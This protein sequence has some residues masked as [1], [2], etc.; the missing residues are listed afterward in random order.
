VR[1]YLDPNSIDSYRLFLRIKGLPRY[2]IVGRVAHF[3]SEYARLLGLE[4][5]NVNGL[6]PYEPIAGLF[7]YQAD[8][9]RLSIHKQKFGVFVDPGYG[10]TL[11][12]AEFARYAASVLPPE[13]CFLMMAPLNVVRQTV[14]E[15]IP[16]FYGDSLKVERIPS[17]ALQDWLLNGKSRIGITN[18]EALKK[19]MKAGRLGGLA[20][21]EMSFAKDA[22]GAYA[23]RLTD[24]GRGLRWKM[25]L[26]GTPAPNDR[27]EYAGYAVFLDAFPNVNAFYARFFVNRGETN[28]RWEMKAHAVNAF[29]RSLSDWCIFMTNPAT[30]GWKDN[31]GTIPPIK[32]TI[33]DVEMTEEQNRRAMA[34][35]K[36]L[37]PE[38]LG[39][40]T[41]RST[42]GQLAKGR[43]NGEDIGTNKP[44]FIRKLVDSWPGEQ[45]IVWCRYDAE[46]ETIKRQFPEAVSL[47]G[48]TPFDKREELIR[49][50]LNRE[51][52]T[53]ISK[54]S[55]LGYGRNM[56]VC[57]QMVFSSIE[58]SYEQY[59][60]CVKRANRVGSTRPL[61]VHLP[62]TP[63]ER[64]MM[65]NVLRKAARIQEETEIQEH[66][67]REN[68]CGLISL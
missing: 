48:K 5:P 61:H 2:R 64:P 54:P 60:Q 62:V 66:L 42:M 25:A 19:V 63:V 24:L 57:T 22:Y 45:T 3:P 47:D 4:E 39:G 58:D 35:S 46:Q 7:D 67:F 13:Q 18:Y 55:I 41:S 17:N 20:C 30:Y 14:E 52:P 37:F 38:F 49:R 43:H 21:D 29:Y 53:L 9:S 59:K 56:Q 16:R 32:V 23:T 26:T 28:E 51:S 12:Q 15:E 10:K 34:E 8:I 6:P 36:T 40:I 50:F 68:G 65:E 33:H 11:I 31:V 44:A 1:L 27:V